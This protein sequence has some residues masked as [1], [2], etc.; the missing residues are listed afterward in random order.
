ML[1]IK[2][3]GTVTFCDSVKTDWLKVVEILWSSITEVFGFDSAAREVNLTKLIFWFVGGGTVNDRFPSLM[4]KSTLDTKDDPLTKT[5]VFV[6]LNVESDT[7][8]LLD[9]PFPEEVK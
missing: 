1:T 2:F 7:I 4:L 3:F 5:N 9:I 6:L 8:K